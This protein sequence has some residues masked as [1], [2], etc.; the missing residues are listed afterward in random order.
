VE[1]EAKFSTL[2]GIFLW[3]KQHGHG[4]KEQYYTPKAFHNREVD[5]KV[6]AE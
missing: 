6:S 3:L 5:R 2:Q 1:Y 4:H